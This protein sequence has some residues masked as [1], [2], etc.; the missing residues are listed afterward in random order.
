MGES[1]GN[2]IAHEY[3]FLI[4]KWHIGMNYREKDAHVVLYVNGEDADYFDISKVS[5]FDDITKAIKLR[6]KVDDELNE[7]INSTQVKPKGI[8]T[9][10]FDY[11]GI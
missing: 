8:L 9:K 3:F 4:S 7:I 6:M 10:I 11:L 2:G 5:V 1:K